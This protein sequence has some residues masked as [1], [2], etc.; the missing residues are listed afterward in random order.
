MKVRIITV[1]MHGNPEEIINVELEQGWHLFQTHVVFTGEG[2]PVS[3]VAVLT[4]ESAT[5]PCPD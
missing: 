5:A 1:P 2:A 4:D 3:L